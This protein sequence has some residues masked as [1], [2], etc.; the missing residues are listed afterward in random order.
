M[1]KLLLVST[2]TAA[3]PLAAANAD[4]VPITGTFSVDEVYSDSQGGPFITTNGGVDILVG[5]FS[6]NLVP[7]VETAAM[8][9][10]SATP[11]ATCWDPG[12]GGGS[13]GGGNTETDP[14][15]ISF[16]F[17]SPSGSATATISATFVAQYA[18]PQLNC[19]PGT[20]SGPTDCLEFGTS[21]ISATF[22]DGEVLDVFL[23]NAQNFL[24]ESPPYNLWTLTPT[25]AFLLVEPTVTDAPE[26]GTLAILGVGLLGLVAA[27]RARPAAH[28]AGVMAVPPLRSTGG[29]ARASRRR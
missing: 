19:A 15:T 18:P 23:N 6:L 3:L 26:P 24:D 10:F 14:M 12:C 13:G 8:P 20:P 16:S 7:G 9:F 5:S 17:T 29:S 27:R 2:I 1:R 4:L 22:T 28:G 25:I 11:Q 21:P